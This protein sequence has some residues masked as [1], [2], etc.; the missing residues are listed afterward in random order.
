[1]EPY[2][3]LG[4]L[5]L[6]GL[7]T[8]GAVIVTGDRITEV[9]RSPRRG[10]LP[11]RVFEA[12]VVAPGLIDLQVNGGFGVEGGQDAGAIRHLAARLPETGVT[13][14]LPTVISSPAD[15][16]P[17]V[18]AAFERARDEVGAVQLGVHL[19]GPFLAPERHG[20]HRKDVIE[21]A[22][23]PLFEAMLAA[24]GVWLMTLAPERAGARDRI[25]RLRHRD[26]VV[27]LGHTDA[28]FDLFTAGVDAGATM[29]THLFNAMSPFAH[30]ASGAV[31]AAL[32]D[33]RVTVGLIAD[34]VH[35][36]PVSLRLA[37]AAKGIE[38][39]ALVTDAMAAAGMPPGRY[40]L[41]GRPVVVD[42]EA[43]RLEDGTL[44]G[45]I[46]TLDQAV[47][48]IV[49]WTGVGPAAAIR[50]ASEIPAA[51]LGLGRKGSLGAGRDA[52]IVLFGDDLRVL[53]TIVGGQFA[54][55]RAASGNE[56]RAFQDAHQPSVDPASS[57]SRGRDA[58]DGRRG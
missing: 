33:D 31:G 50:M 10:D 45:S 56:S 25:R 27:S 24:D 19:E 28:T 22:D 47:R 52:D 7:L 29:A 40:A 35:C 54:F 3:V 23:D 38:R 48:N 51:V 5:A 55:N 44:A 58:D 57:W 37:V 2:A 53:A 49:R 15:D 41:G 20:A 13:A 9:R 46:L 18:F 1:M 4:R 21:A 43:V 36:H 16:Y 17:A 12:D 6:G 11:D 14:F 8:D 26:I 39:I 42:E 32:I 30:R 34:G